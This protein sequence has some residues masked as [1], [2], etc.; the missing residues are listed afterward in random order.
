MRRKCW[1]EWNKEAHGVHSTHT[2]TA[3]RAH[4][5]ADGAR[6][7]I[8]SSRNHTVAEDSR[9]VFSQNSSQTHAHYCV[10]NEMDS[11]RILIALQTSQE[12]KRIESK[13]LTVVDCLALRCGLFV[14]TTAIDRGQN[15]AL[16]CQF[17]WL[18][19]RCPIHGIYPK[20]LLSPNDIAPDSVHHSYT[21]HSDQILSVR[22]TRNN[23]IKYD[24]VI[25]RLGSYLLRGI[26][27]QIEFNL[28]WIFSGVDRSSSDGQGG[29][30]IDT[31]A[32]RFVWRDEISESL[33]CSTSTSSSTSAY[34]SDD[35]GPC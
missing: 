17:L 13:L 33:H 8:G 23:F 27:I 29:D 11:C 16:T 14:C 26:K 2:H 22:Q 4:V 12:Q 24:F 5:A 28:T 20:V 25:S 19:F 3:H 15:G 21:N 30:A 18:S 7:S 34:R 1:K 9:P 35:S 10:S 31:F 32:I 6:I